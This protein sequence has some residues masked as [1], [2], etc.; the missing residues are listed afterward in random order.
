[1]TGQL[2][3][4]QALPATALVERQV[5]LA[6]QSAIEESLRRTDIQL[7]FYRRGKLWRFMTDLLGDDG[8]ISFHRF[9]IAAWTLVLGT[10]FVEQVATQLAMPEFNA[11]LL[12][13]MGI[14]SG[15]YIGFK[16]PATRN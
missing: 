5:N 3:A 6:E 16:I 8:V 9:Q 13:L 11:T 15:T 14:S 12:G 2:G 1:L 4:L 10:I 7:A